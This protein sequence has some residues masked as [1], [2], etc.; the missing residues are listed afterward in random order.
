MSIIPSGK[1]YMIA[2][3]ALTAMTQVGFDQLWHSLHRNSW[4]VN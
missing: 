4:I 1:V 2:M 3:D